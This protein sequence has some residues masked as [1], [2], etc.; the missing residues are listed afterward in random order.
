MSRVLI[1]RTWSPFLLS[2][3]LS[4]SPP[5]DQDNGTRPTGSEQF[6]LGS[7]EEKETCHY[8]IKTF[9]P[10]QIWVLDYKTLSLCSSYLPG[11]K[12]QFLIRSSLFFRENK[13]F[14]ELSCFFSLT[15]DHFASK[16][17]HNFLED[18]SSYSIYCYFKQ[19]AQTVLKCLALAHVLRQLNFY[20]ILLYT[21]EILNTCNF[22]NLPV[23]NV[24]LNHN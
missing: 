18:I 4:L 20:F 14:S 9:T 13:G 7:E 3:V 12:R 16:R 19:L 17:T 10:L 15:K 5:A 22:T 24:Q 2:S 11:L 21:R 23:T 6:H 1:P 8:P